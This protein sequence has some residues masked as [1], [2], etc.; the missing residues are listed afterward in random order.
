MKI[1]WLLI[2]LV[3]LCRCEPI[4]GPDGNVRASE[5]A[6]LFT[7]LSW[8][9]QALFDG[10]ETGSEY[11]DYKSQT[12]WSAEKYEARLNSFS[13][14]IQEL[15]KTGEINQAEGMPDLIGLMEVEN[16]KVLEDLSRRIKGGY[17]WTCFANTSGSA[18]GIGVLSRLPLVK[19]RVHS[20][21][22]DG[23]E[24]PR[25]I[26]EVCIEKGGNSLVFFICHWKSKLGGDTATETLRRAS[27]RVILRRLRELKEEEPDL[28]VIIMGDLNENHD[29]FFRREGKIISALLPDDP[30]AAELA[31]SE[32]DAAGA[33]AALQNDFLILSGENPPQSRN[34]SSGIALYSPWENTLAGGSYFYK[35]TWET[36]DHFLL[37]DALFDGRGWEFSSAE[38]IKNSPFTAASGYPASYNPRNG[39]GLSDH[40]PLLLMLKHG[41]NS[42]TGET[43]NSIQRRN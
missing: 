16:L 34:F 4:S 41:G 31:A 11:D 20:I 22:N 9:V 23:E 18:L 12:G 32:A 6:R 43:G 14:A 33:E 29:E 40:L 19:T 26:L 37:T 25:P 27:A 36:I 1:K 3:L 15:F 10:T 5:D 24:L 21:N 42:P 8:N 28:P 39:S 7:A 17:N 35:N 30:R 13:R 38:A 2:N